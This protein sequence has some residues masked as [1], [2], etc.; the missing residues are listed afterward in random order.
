MVLIAMMFVFTVA[1]VLCG[2]AIWGSIAVGIEMFKHRDIQGI[3][4]YDGGKK[5]DLSS[6]FDPLPGERFYG[7]NQ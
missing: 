2:I 5:F 7:H 3:T 6:W 4:Y 1:M